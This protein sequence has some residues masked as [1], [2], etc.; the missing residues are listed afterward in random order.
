M[1]T[2]LR[3]SGAGFFDE[4]KD[5][6]TMYLLFSIFAGCIGTFLSL[7][8]RL[9]LEQPGLQDFPTRASTMCSSLRME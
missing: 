7:M 9:E 1:T 2:R 8:M 5:I 4:P 3:S 6:G